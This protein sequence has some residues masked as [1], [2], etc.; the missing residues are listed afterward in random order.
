MGHFRKKHKTDILRN[1]PATETPDSLRI[2][3]QLQKFSEIEIDGD[4]EEDGWTLIRKQNVSKK[5]LPTEDVSVSEEMDLRN[6]YWLPDDI[7]GLILKFV[8]TFELLK[9]LR[10]FLECSNFLWLSKLLN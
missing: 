7:W 3:F 8:P 5:K 9:C 4:K 2:Y 1:V 6:P 10:E